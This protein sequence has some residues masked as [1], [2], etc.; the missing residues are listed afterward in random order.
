MNRSLAGYNLPTELFE[1]DF[2]A[3]S[4]GA[5]SV[6][7]D[8]RGFIKTQIAANQRDPYKI[9]DALF[10]VRHP[11]L[12][13]KRLG[14]EQTDLTKEWLS[15]LH[16]LVQPILAA[17]G[18]GTGDADVAAAQA[19]AR[20][21]VPGMP[22]ITIQQLIEKWRPSIAPE[23]PMPLLLGFIRFESGG[24]FNDATHGSPRNQPPYTQPAFYE[25]GLFQTPAGLHGTCTT[26]DHRSCANAPPGREVPGDPST[27]ARLCKKIGANP[28]DWTNPTTQVR[29]GLLD[30]KTSAD[31]I[32]AAYPDLFPKPGGD[33]FLRMAVLMPFARGGGFTRAFLRTYRTNLAQLPED[34]RWDFLRGKR[35][36]AWIFDAS[37]VDKKMALAAKLG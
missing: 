12:S 18:T 20:K 11:E 35:V 19:I 25:L 28:Q 2:E 9:T 17:S 32:R 22:G 21:P 26:G 36:S 8:E 29:V 16:N 34:Q 10:Y 27:W 37:N 14:K 13:G 6:R 30:L 3:P 15:I 5:G 31:A 33:W 1:Y 7:V 23:I 4:Q 24:N